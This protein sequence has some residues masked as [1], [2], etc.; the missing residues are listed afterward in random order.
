MD[1]NLGNQHSEVTGKG[2]LLALLFSLC[3]TFSDST[4]CYHK[5]TEETSELF[6]LWNKFCNNRKM[7][8][9]SYENY[10]HQ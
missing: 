3:T 2:K 7:L 4:R 5:L 1:L 6:C 9:V 8:I 10:L